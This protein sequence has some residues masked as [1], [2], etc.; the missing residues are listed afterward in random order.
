MKLADLTRNAQSPETAF[1]SLCAC[2]AIDRNKPRYEQFAALVKALVARRAA[3]RGAGIG[4]FGDEALRAAL[5]RESLYVAW[6]LGIAA[7]GRQAPAD[8]E[9]V[10][11]A[12][13]A[14]DDPAAL[15]RACERAWEFLGMPRRGP[16]LVQLREN[17]Q[18]LSAVQG[19]HYEEF[20]GRRVRASDGSFVAL[21]QSERAPIV[22]LIYR[23]KGATLRV[24]LLGKRLCLDAETAAAAA[25]LAGSQRDALA[26]AVALGLMGALSEQKFPVQVDCWLVP[27][28]QVAVADDASIEIVHA[29][30]DGHA[31]LVDALTLALRGLPHLIADLATLA[32]AIRGLPRGPAAGAPALAENTG[33]AR[34]D[35]LA[36]LGIAWGIELLRRWLATKPAT[37]TSQARR[38]AGLR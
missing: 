4:R 6:T 5:A 9:G 31:A 16:A 38:Y 14:Y 3:P 26:S 1:E 15:A 35:D 11:S 34:L 28:A 30:S 8:A 24:T 23:P 21:G 37:A 33:A 20:E 27:T 22:H 36:P 19:W 17:L 18:R 2:V 25:L 10:P 7:S 29:G 12:H 13:G 32:G